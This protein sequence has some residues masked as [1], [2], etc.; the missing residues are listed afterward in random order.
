MEINVFVS[1]SQNVI[2][3]L[4]HMGRQYVGVVYRGFKVD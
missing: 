3:V 1:K 2:I 4:N